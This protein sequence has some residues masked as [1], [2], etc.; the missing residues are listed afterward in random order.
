M[1]FEWAKPVT[2]ERLVIL[3]DLSQNTGTKG[4]V[5]Q[6]VVRS[7]LRGVASTNRRGKD[8]DGL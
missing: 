4:R 7:P 3:A 8:T 5:Y 6:A 1:S 2:M